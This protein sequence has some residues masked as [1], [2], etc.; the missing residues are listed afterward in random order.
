MCHSSI[1]REGLIQDKQPHLSLKTIIHS[2]IIIISIVSILLFAPL[3]FQ[4]TPV[5]ASVCVP[6]GGTGLTASMV[7]S[8]HQK[9][10]G[11]T[12]NAAGCD[13]GIYVGPGTTDVKIIGV[14]VTG[15]N[16]HAIFVQDASR[17]TIEHSLVT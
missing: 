7:A 12:I 11:T 9:I 10:R 8:S 14:T 17:I 13:V 2:R 16:D 15:A 6:A 4:V 5:S 1:L 3:G